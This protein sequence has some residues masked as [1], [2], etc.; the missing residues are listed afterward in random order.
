MIL[1]LSAKCSDMCSAVLVSDK[2][3][4]LK[5]RDGYVPSIMPEG[6]GDYVDIDI[7]V[8]TGKILNWKVPTEAQL[9]SFIHG[10]NEDDECEECEECG[11]WHDLGDDCPPEPF[12]A[13]AFDK[14]YGLEIVIPKQ[15]LWL[16]VTCA[17]ADNRRPTI[18]SKDGYCEC[19]RQRHTIYCFMVE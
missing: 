14:E 12:D 11:T 7:D 6:G 16:C 19:C 15:Q 17:A 13:K 10:K 3:K 8:A 5:E 9:N 2:G 1:K 4:V 18:T